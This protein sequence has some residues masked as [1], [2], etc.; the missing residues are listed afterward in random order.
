MKERITFIIVIVILAIFG[1]TK[2][3]KSPVEI[4]VEVIVYKDSVTTVI[5]TDTIFPEKT[6]VYIEKEIPKYI[7]LKDTIIKSYTDSLI[8][9]AF[10]VYIYDDI[11]GE[12]K[13]RYFE[14]VNK[15]PI[16][17]NNDS[18][19]VIT[20]IEYRDV[21]KAA[22]DIGNFIG[23]D[24]Y[25]NFRDTVATLGARYVRY[26]KNKAYSIGYSLNGYVSGGIYV[27]F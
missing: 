22:P 27:R 26:N 16:I 4:P 7:Y 12:L 13:N 18:E 2:Y 19:K 8:T 11:L 6:I 21:V 1:Y 25:Y 17:I 9:E 14:Y 15:T 20:K 24:G 3:T 23:V 10:D 5:K